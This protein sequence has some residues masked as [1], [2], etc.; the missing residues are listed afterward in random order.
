[1]ESLGAIY[2]ALNAKVSSV[3]S[4]EYYFIY[5]HA[6]AAMG[7]PVLMSRY[8]TGSLNFS[9]QEELS[10]SLQGLRNRTVTPPPVGT[11]TVLFTHQGKF[12][13]T[14]SYYL[15]AGQSI[16]FQPDNSGTPRVIVRLPL[17]DWLALA[18]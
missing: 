10:H 7:A 1:M 17:D 9:D 18:N 2:P 15:N 11:N 16:I 14:Y 8:L 3:L 13:K 4:S 5:H 12:E 6:L